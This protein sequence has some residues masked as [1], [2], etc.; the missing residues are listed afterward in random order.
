M[1]S[2]V[3]PGLADP[4]PVLEAI[5]AGGADAVLT[6][7]GVIRQFRDQLKSVGLIMRMDGGNSTIRGAAPEM[8][9]LY[10][11]EDAL[12]LGAD[13][14]ICMGFPGTALEPRT[15]G[16]IAQLANQCGTWG[17]PLMA[18]VL[19]GG[20]MNPELGTPENTRL[21]VRLAVELGAD[22][23][24][25]SFT[26]PA[27]S[28]RTVVENSYRPVLV[29]GGSVVD[30]SSLLKMVE[31]SMQAGAAGVV[32]GRNVWNNPNPKAMVEAITRIVHENAS[33][34]EALDHLASS[35]SSR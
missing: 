11:V 14:V 35:A 8:R 25:T 3:Y 28:F 23:I 32:L 5:V 21:A 1:G 10:S 20:F 12:K 31:S 24:K 6:S 7:P 17:I 13:A 34:E 29:L 26:P 16:N 27:E 9:L 2:N 22:M 4:G 30:V 15:L 19:P 18:E 33:I